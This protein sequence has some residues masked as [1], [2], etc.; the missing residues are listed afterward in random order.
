MK[1]TEKIPN[2]DINK[3]DK[4]CS[5]KLEMVSKYPIVDGKEVFFEKVTATKNNKVY[6]FYS[7]EAETPEHLEN[8]KA[9]NN[10]NGFKKITNCGH[11]N[12]KDL[13]E[14]VIKKGSL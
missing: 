3:L 8:I 14:K 11:I 9:I 12:L 2:Q 5:I 1:T 6:I 4:N 10:V 13:T 7:S